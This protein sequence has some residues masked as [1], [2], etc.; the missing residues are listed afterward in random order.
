MQTNFVRPALEEDLPAIIRLTRENRAL[1]ARLEPT[2]WRAAADADESHAAFMATVVT[3]PDITKRVLEKDGRV[4]GFVVSLKHP[5]GWWFIDDVCLAEEADWSTDGVDLLKAIEERPAAMTAPHKDEA[6]I[7]AAAQVGLELVST[8]RS[9]RFDQDQQ[10]D[11]AHD[12][13][14]PGQPPATL[15]ASPFHVF[16]PAMTPESIS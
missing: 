14:E 3:N 13:I 11:L 10:L 16:G 8:F 12:Q 5:A 6:R 15:V 7:R 9:I 2:F 4:I 1:L